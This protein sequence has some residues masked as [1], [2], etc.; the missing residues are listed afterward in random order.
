MLRLALVR[1]AGA[2]AI[3]TG[4]A[5]GQHATMPLPWAFTPWRAVAPPAV[6][7]PD[8][9]QP[10]DRFVSAAQRQQGLRANPRADYATLLRRAAYVLTGLPPTAE[11]RQRLAAQ[12]DEAAFAALVDELLASP[13]YGERQARHWLDLARYSDSNGLD[14]NLAF[15][16]AW[17]YR[18]WVVAAHNQDLPFDR[19]AQLQIAGDLMVDEPGVGI[20]GYTATGFL[21]LGPRMLAEQD[22]PK[23]VLDTV[24]E[25]LDLVGRTFLGQTLG[26]ARCHDHKFDPISAADYYALAGIFHST[27]SFHDTGFVSRWRDRALASDAALAE[28]QQRVDAAKALHDGLQ[29]ARQQAASDQRQHLLAD[30][31]RYLLAAEQLRTVAV[32]VEAEHSP[33]TSLRADHRTWGSPEVGVLH[34]AGGGEQF[35]EW[36]VQIPHAGHYRLEIRY[37]AQESR[38]MRLYVDGNLLVEQ[39]LVATTGGWLPAHQEWHFVTEWQAGAGA[40]TLRLVAHGPHVPHLDA[41]LLTPVDLASHLPPAASAGLLPPALRRAL[42]VLAGRSHHPLVAL[43]NELAS[44]DPFDAAIASRAGVGGL[45]AVLLGGLPPADLREFAARLQTLLASAADATAAAN[46]KQKDGQPVRLFGDS[47]EHARALLFD[48]G[49]LLDLSAEQLHEHLPAATLADL[50]SRDAAH[51]AAV[52]AIPPAPPLVMA[53]AEGKV[54]DLPI[55]LRGNHLTLA[56]TATPRGVLSRLTDLA[57]APA[58]PSDRSGRRELAAWLFA[59]ELPLAAR[60]H[61]NRIWQRAFGEGLCR[62]PSNFGNRGDVPVHQDLLDWLAKELVQSGW[63]QK[64]L[65]RTILLS[66][67]WQSTSQHQEA[68]AA[69]DPDNR[70][71]WRQQR[72]RLDAEAVRDALL[73]TSGQLDPT[74]GGSLLASKDR[75]YVTNDQS[76]QQATYDSRRRSLYLPVIRNAMYDLFTAFDYVDP[77]V[78]L[79][80]RPTS[81]VATQALLLLNSELILEQSRQLV[82]ATFATLPADADDTTRT[83]A[84]WQRALARA[85]DAVERQRAAQWLATANAERPEAGWP[86][87][88][89]VLLASS[90]FLYVD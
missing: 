78:H 81:A 16:N 31:G 42:A 34:T 53:V 47:N 52:A 22:K 36:D 87:L 24:D 19:F 82:A 25:Q 58:M 90:E 18:D 10:L 48:R 13:H 41:L 1:A 61:A 44:A 8:W 2:L 84:L 38:P 83:T 79:D 72:R 49:G 35:A 6:S 62:T 55:H 7:D 12:P 54:V 21:A 57:Q 65:W 63:S 71:L 89:Q 3:A 14:E 29:T 77:S 50:A 9:Q 80:C 37:A 88:A 20:D 43:W 74:L 67:T 85:P 27:S 73:A 60:V 26:C 17:R 68:A 23:L 69:L 56:D 86:G 32:F 64:Q 4:G 30:A 40:H 5:V 28:R 66:R 59:P 70:Y 39:A 15:A 46:G 76:G 11:Q 51:R 45:S 75:D 33:R